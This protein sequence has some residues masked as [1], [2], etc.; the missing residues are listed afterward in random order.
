MQREIL[1]V[2][3]EWKRSLH[4]KPIL[5]RGARQVGKTYVVE[6]L[7][8]T[9]ASFVAINLER[10]IKIRECFNSLVPHEIIDNL[11]IL[12]QKIITP[13]ATLLF[14]DEIQ[15]HPR[16]I[17]SL[18]YF[19]EQIPTLHVIAAGSL[20]EFVLHQEKISMPVGRIEYLYMHPCS[21]TE[22]LMARSSDALL[23]K[24]QTCSQ[25]NMLSPV[26]HQELL[27]QF[28]TYM[29][30]GGMPE[31]LAAYLATEKI[32]D[33][34]RAQQS[35]LQ[36]YRDDFG[37]YASQAKL[38]YLQKVFDKTPGIIG[39]Q[40]KYNKI[41]AEFKSRDLKQ[42]IDMLEY[43]GVIKRIIATSASGLPLISTT[44]EKKFKLQFLDIGLVQCASE[45]GSALMHI[46]LSKLN[47][48]SLAEQIVGQSLLAYSDPFIK[49]HLF[50]WARDAKSSSAEIDFVINIGADII[51]LEVKSG[52]HGR[53][54]SLQIFLK[55]K[56][57]PLGV[58]IS[59]APLSYEK[60][61]LN[62]PF[63]LIKE[64]PRLVQE[65]RN[66]II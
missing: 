52:A 51:P 59:A 40:I 65:A 3:L 41:D 32:Y 11:S 61:I 54:K 24:L 8:K 19:R 29:I 44:N 39:E 56:N 27:N 2:L 6:E 12:T 63:Y 62:I 36:T 21:F 60:N 20:L 5:L 50:F 26:I 30:T 66:T 42:A 48:G 23:Q 55:E 4:R 35:I 47:D 9:F 7:G 53:L 10:D 25:K 31:A 15:A 58:K 14:I 28:K 34:Q 64:L 45:L 22:Y 13:G 43:A 37:K 57:L 49:P 16:A 18:R 1:A 33:A 17:E 46:D 38:R